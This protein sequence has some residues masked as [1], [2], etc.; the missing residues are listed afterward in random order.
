ME[1]KEL[2]HYGVIGMRWGVRRYQ[3]YSVKPRESGKTGK[4]VG[5]AKKYAARLSKPIT[6][7]KNQRLASNSL[8]RAR[9]TNINKLSDSELQKANNR[10]ENERRFKQLTKTGNEE[11][12]DLMRHL[13]L[14]T[15]SAT[16]A[17]AAHST[18]NMYIGFL[19]DGYAAGNLAL[20]SVDIGQI[21]F[22][23]F[24]NN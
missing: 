11:V 16:A 12:I 2:K 21:A 10:L 23:K 18:G 17:T 3:P 5:L 1:D 13:G 24:R 8:K 22:D 9:T 15:L 14:A 7:Y 20:A 6:N 4:E 19:F